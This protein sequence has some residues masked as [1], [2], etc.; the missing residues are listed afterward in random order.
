[1][2]YALILQLIGAAWYSLIVSVDGSSLKRSSFLA[3]FNRTQI[4]KYL[5][6]N[7]LHMVGRFTLGINAGATKKAL[8][9]AQ[10]GELSI[11]AFAAAVVSSTLAFPV[12]THALNRYGFDTSS[13]IIGLIIGLFFVFVSTFLL[14][15]FRM[16]RIGRRAFFASM[17]AFFFYTL[18]F[19]G[20]GWL[21]VLLLLSLNESI[22]HNAMELIGIGTAAWLIGFVIPGAPGG[23]GIREAVLITGLA[24]I[25]ITPTTATGVALG[26]RLVTVLGDGLLALIAFL[27]RKQ[28]SM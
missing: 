23:L 27:L 1:M 14:L 16:V 2:V 22:A 19:I 28:N 21:I 12:V 4:Y 6:S 5:P 18:F 7:V 10:I 20:N 17:K 11:M 25:G 15:R 3:I 26:N 13:L 8:A 9:F 24:S